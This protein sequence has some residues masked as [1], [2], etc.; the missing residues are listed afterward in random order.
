MLNGGSL[1]VLGSNA[2]GTFQN[3]SGLI[4]GNSTGVRGGGGRLTVTSGADQNVMLTI[5]TITRNTGVTID[6]ATVNT[7]TGTA[8]IATNGDEC[9]S[10]TVTSKMFRPITLRT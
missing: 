2:D 4:L 1:E 6:F 10:G 8:S 9:G 5:G 7:G 3:V